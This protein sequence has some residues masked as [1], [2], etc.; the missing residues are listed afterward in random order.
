MAQRNSSTPKWILA[1]VALAVIATAVIV[2]LWR[3]GSQTDPLSGNYAVSPFQL[4]GALDESGFEHVPS[5]WKFRFPADHGRHDAYRTEWWHVSGL[6][7]D[8]MRR[9][10]GVQLV[11]MRIAL[12]AQPQERPSRWAASEVYAGLFSISDPAQNRLRT[13]QRTARA[14][15]DLAGT[16]TD[17]IRVWV[18]NWR[19]EQIGSDGRAAQLKLHLAAENTELALKL[20]NVQPLIDTGDL[21]ERRPERTPPFQFYIQPRMTTQGAVT[22]GGPRM[23]VSGNLSMEHAWGEL[24][25][26]GGPVARDRFTLYLDDGRALFC[27]RTHRV[28]GTG[29]AS[30]A[31]VLISRAG[32]PVVLSSDQIDLQPTDHWVSGRTGARYPIRW[33]LG[34]PGQEIEVDLIPYYEDQEGIA[35]APFWVGPVRLQGSSA[36]STRGGV[37]LV[38][39]NGYEGS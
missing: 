30:T 21:G 6:L 15:L 28:D 33:A 20:Q 38:Q 9:H 3:G 11:L 19:M 16:E 22:M 12:S 13:Y 35:W 32:N 36:M 14:A 27:I 25:L 10:M 1:G 29:T 39:L 23:E 5:P 2:A 24:P 7:Q 34:V 17:P 18:E 4:V 31:G 8:E 37:G 26:P